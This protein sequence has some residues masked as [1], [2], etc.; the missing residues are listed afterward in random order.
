MSKFCTE[1]GF[2][3]DVSIALKIEEQAKKETDKAFELLMEISKSPDL[4]RE[5]EEFR[6]KNQE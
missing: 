6:K 3:L 5:F 4:F 1:C 2:A